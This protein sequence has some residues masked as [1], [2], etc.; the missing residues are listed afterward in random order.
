[1][2]DL[3]RRLST[4]LFFLAPL[5]TPAVPQT[6]T[7]PQPTALVTFYSSGSFWKTAVPGYKYGNF[8][9]RIFDEYDQLANI[10]PGYFVTFKLDAGPHTFSDNSW[11][12][13][14]PKG[15]AHLKIDLVADHHYYIGTYIETTPL[16]VIAAFRIEERTC[17]QAQKDNTDTHP[18]ES[19]HLMKYGSATVV[20]E[21]S[22]PTCS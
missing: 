2:Y 9:G 11:V 10:S 8:K 19:K 16:V 12:I 7:P 18:L 1:M 14:S 3:A 17:E 21:T 4:L 13:A 6:A 22:F 5:A 15:G 20:T